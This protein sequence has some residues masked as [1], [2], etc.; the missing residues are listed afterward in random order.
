MICN[1]IKKQFTVLMPVYDREDINKLFHMAV[2]SVFK[3]TLQPNAFI[4]VVNGPVSSGLKNQ[5]IAFEI[6]HHIQVIWLTKN[7]GIAKALN[8]GLSLV[9]TEWVIRADADDYNLPNRFE[10]L[11]KLINGNVDIIGSAIEE[12]DINGRQIATKI[13]PLDHQQI[14]NYAKYRN[15]F[16]HMTVAFRVCL[17]LKCGGYPDIYLKEDYALWVL[18]IKNGA[19]T[20]NTSQ[21]LVHATTGADM[22]KRRGGLRYANAEIDLQKHL[23]KCGVKGYFSGFFHGFVRSVIFLMPQ[24]MRGWIYENFLRNS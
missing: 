19:Y 21:V 20:M 2:S 17:A 12:V 16:N 22:Y 15:P 4:L 11:V 1:D 18:M 3:N 8:I 9:K 6:D 24:T 7:V 10:E 13:S 14:L 23:I 5:I